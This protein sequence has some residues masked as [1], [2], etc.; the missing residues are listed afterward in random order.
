MEKNSSSITLARKAWI[1][2]LYSC[3][4]VNFLKPFIKSE[5]SDLNQLVWAWLGLSFRR[6]SLILFWCSH[7]CSV[8]LLEFARSKIWF[9]R[10]AWKN[11]KKSFVF[12]VIADLRLVQ[13]FFI[14]SNQKRDFLRRQ[15]QYFAPGYIGSV[16][17]LAG[18]DDKIKLSIIYQVQ[19]YNP[20]RRFLDHSQPLLWSDRNSWSKYPWSS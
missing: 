6:R 2:A 13:K 4:D 8:W 20:S 10:Q 14:F 18:F 12:P 1:V 7:Y 19:G 3:S 11:S 17:C 15:L 16:T 9:N 5:I